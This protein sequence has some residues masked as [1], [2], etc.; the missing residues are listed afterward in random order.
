MQVPVVPLGQVAPGYE[1]VRDAF[2]ALVAERPGWSGAVAAYVDG[3][4]VVD[5]WAGPDWHEDSVIL[6]Y[7]ASKGL[8]ATVIGLLVDDGVLDLDDSVA[9]YWPEFGAAGK[10]A[11]TVR[12]LCSHQAGLHVVDG[13]ATLDELV[14]HEP[15]ARKLAA[16]QPAWE[17]GTDVL[18][19]GVTI[20]P[21]LDELVRRVTGAPLREVFLERIARPLGV[22][23]EV[24]LGLP[25]SEDARLVDVVYTPEVLELWADLPQPNVPNDFGFREMATSVP[26]LRAGI[27]SVSGVGSAR[28]LARIYAACVSDVDGVRLLHDETVAQTAE[29]QVFKHDDATGADISFSIGYQGLIP[30]RILADVGGPGSFG[31]DGAGGAVGFAS[32]RHGL[33]FGFT[34]NTVPL[35]PGLDRGAATLASAVLACSTP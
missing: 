34:P 32:P 2:A 18:Y 3:E 13:G 28:G 14:R 27:P 8:A 23:R 15:L 21:L 11:V 4:A 6:L 20:G 25:E 24:F 16:Q 7:S 5:L 12:V 17:P 22:E 31:H 19:H 30:G 33:G 35:E 29:P 26:L 10:D 1:A 9:K